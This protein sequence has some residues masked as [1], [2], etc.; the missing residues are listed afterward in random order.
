MMLS[1]L[2]GTV[3]ELAFAKTSEATTL[4]LPLAATAPVSAPATA[5]DTE[6]GSSTTSNTCNISCVI[7]QVFVT[8]TRFSVCV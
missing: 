6:K 7:L 4:H 1:A 2:E 3:G 8:R 5:V